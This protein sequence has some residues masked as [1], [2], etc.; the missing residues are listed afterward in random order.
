MSYD[1]EMFLWDKASDEDFHAFEANAD[2]SPKEL[3][4]IL[5]DNPSGQHVHQ[6]NENSACPLCNEFIF[7]SK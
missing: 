2:F 6:L 3:L 5:K 1:E 7:G 4:T